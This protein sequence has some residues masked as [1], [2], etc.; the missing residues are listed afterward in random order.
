[1]NEKR[2][3]LA[4]AGG[5][6]L[7]AS[8]FGYGI[9]TTFGAISDVKTESEAKRTEIADAK[10]KLDE[11]RKL[12]ERAIVLRESVAALASVLP[13]DKEVEEFVY[14]MSE[15]CAETG[16]NLREMTRKSA[17]GKAAKAQLFEKI[18]YQIG[19]RGKLWEFL[20]C[21]HRIESAKRFVMVP[22]VKI[23]G[24]SRDRALDDVMHSF[25]IEV[26]TYAYNP[27]KGSQIENIPSYEKRR[28]GLREEIEQAKYTIEQPPVE[29]AGQKGR[30]D[31]F[32]DPRLPATAAGKEG[33][34]PVEQQT[35]LV[36]KLRERVDEVVGL[37][38]ELKESTNF[39]RRFEIRALVDERLPKLEG[40][41]E[42][43]VKQG[44]ITYPLLVRT[45]Q[46][47]VREALAKAKKTIMSAGGDAGPSPKEL[48]ELVTR[49]REALGNGRIKEAIESAKPILEKA[50]LFEKDAL[51]AA[52]I[53]ELRKL[54]RDAHIAEKFEQKKVVIGG[55]IVD[56]TKKVA[57]V[58]NRTVE[59]GDQIDDDLV[60]ADIQEDG[61]TFLLENVHITKKW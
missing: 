43:T 15:L 40:D 1:V 53:A 30:R 5:T 7:A 61:V 3:L 50:P 39:L 59:P 12:E 48:G 57:V 24:G 35:E 45:F 14:K 52:Q 60:I 11:V 19:V 58:N 25:E 49:V 18:T 42:A 8:G 46:N 2:I 20:E 32:S 41:V 6:L 47:E 37:A 56:N 54:D 4:I 34:L 21:L 29:F 44:S 28:E 17:S 31:I 16:V 33:D 38:A 36:A 55:V 27:G 10:K 9:Y 51:R 22:K 23:S 26:E 13:T